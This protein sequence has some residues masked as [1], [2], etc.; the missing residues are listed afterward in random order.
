M[1][2]IIHFPF[3]PHPSLFTEAEEI[4]YYCRAVDLPA[5]IEDTAGYDRK[6]GRRDDC[7]RTESVR[8]AIMQ[9]PDWAQT[10]M[11]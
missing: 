8:S 9:L 10:L 1:S 5:P 2:R 11:S 4:S 6:N 7:K 3:D